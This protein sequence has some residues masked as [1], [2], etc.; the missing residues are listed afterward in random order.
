MNPEIEKWFRRHVLAVVMAEDYLDPHWEKR[1]DEAY[2]QALARKLKSTLPQST[3]EL[4]F[5]I[6]TKDVEEVSIATAREV[7][8]IRKLIRTILE[9]EAP[10]DE[11]KANPLYQTYPEFFDRSPEVLLQIHQ[12]EQAMGLARHGM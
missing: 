6:P 5:A 7:V 2:V 8:E 3:L 4:E 9:S 1:C 12:I 11:L 10:L